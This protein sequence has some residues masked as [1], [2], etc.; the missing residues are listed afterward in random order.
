M[1]YQDGSSL[2]SHIFRWRNKPRGLLL[3]FNVIHLRDRIKRVL[4]IK[5]QIGIATAQH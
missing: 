1:N 5:Y 2:Y 3:N 4:N